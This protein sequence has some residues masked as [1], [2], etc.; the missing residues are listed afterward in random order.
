[1][2]TY[3]LIWPNGEKELRSIVLD[4][5]GNPRVD[6]LQPNPLPD[7]WQEPQIL[8]LIK[9][10]QPD[11]GAWEPNVVWFDD[12]VERQW[13]VGTLAPAPTF[14]A[15][16]IVSRHFSPYQIAAL[17][18]LELSLA[19]AGKSLGPNM[20]AA[21]AWLESVMLGWAVDPTPKPILAF[22]DPNVTFEAASA[23]AVTELQNL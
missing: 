16:Q 18:R 21:K 20:S 15:E 8:P 5:E 19:Q 13:I 22:G 11:Q 7:D 12:R 23:E 4:D 10:P 17:Q 9:L 2:K 3:G 6:T 14:T 1:M